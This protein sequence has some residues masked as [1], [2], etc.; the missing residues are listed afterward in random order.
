MYTSYWHDMKHGIPTFPPA[1]PPSTSPIHLF[2]PPF[3]W[4][5]RSRKALLVAVAWMF[6]LSF[7][8]TSSV[9][10]QEART[11]SALFPQH[12]DTVM[13]RA[14]MGHPMARPEPLSVEIGLLPLSLPADTP[15][16]VEG[17]SWRKRTRPYAL[18]GMVVGG[19]L[20]YAAHEEVFWK[21]DRDSCDLG[22]ISY[23]SYS[24]PIQIRGGR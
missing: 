14:S 18:A 6:S 5:N 8:A 20:G 21:R 1:E 11:E 16:V 19:L 4:R 12:F 10:A 24:A 17:R 7:L 15:R 22:D 2:D 23:C 13:A 3:G 9:T